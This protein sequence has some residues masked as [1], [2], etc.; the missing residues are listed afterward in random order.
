ML[1]AVLAALM[2]LGC[3]M[4]EMSFENADSPLFS[5][6]KDE[7]S[8]ANVPAADQ[9]PSGE[10]VPAVPAES[11][12]EAKDESVSSAAG[13]D[14]S[15]APAEKAPSDSSMAEEAKKDDSS[16][17]TTDSS[18]PEG[19]K[20]GKEKK[21]AVTDLRQLNV[22]MV[23]DGDRTYDADADTLLA[24]VDYTWLVLDDLSGELC[25]EL[26][27]ALKDE[28]SLLGKQMKTEFADLKTASEK[29]SGKN[30][31][32]YSAERKM[33]PVRT[34]NLV[35]SAL[36]V[37]K[38]QQ[39]KKSDM[40]LETL[41][42]DAQTGREIELGD[43]VDTKELPALLTEIYED[44]YPDEPVSGFEKLVAGYDDGDYVWALSREGLNFYFADDDAEHP[45]TVQ[46]PRSENKGLFSDEYADMPDSFAVMFNENS[47]YAFDRFEDGKT[48]LLSV[49]FDSDS[50]A[51]T[52]DLNGDTAVG[53]FDA[54]AVTP[55]LVRTAEER[56]YIYVVLTLDNDYQELAVFDITDAPVFLGIDGN[57]GI[58]VTI[59]I[60]DGLR[61]RI[62]S[63]S[64]EELMFSE[65]IDLLST[66]DGV[67]RY[68]VGSDGMPEAQDDWCYVNDD[69][70]LT[71]LTGFVADIVNPKTGRILEEGAKI[72]KGT[73]LKIHRTDGKSIVD[74]MTEDDEIIRVDVDTSGGWPQT[75]DGTDIEK[76][77]D[78]IRFAG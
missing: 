6:K 75:I 53:R 44:M 20:N 11:A 24:S 1:A 49:S 35:F 66:Y 70:E 68:S 10:S 54:Y 18:A 64:P 71:V 76:L 67:R 28:A 33:V 48:D 39:G 32:Q 72:A 16:A 5:G 21:P 29:A 62:F 13:Q 7:S 9:S 51:V 8:A 22:K 12:N 69:I 74:L 52:V 17:D 50:G 37:V 36:T 42:L 43:I 19:A 34:D 14:N 26:A 58:P 59:D 2:L 57:V 55:V 3:S 47:G 45:V 31:T 46:L 65:H 15:A 77:F 56:Y 63:G 27:D 30:K 40:S 73:E 4:P 60:E 23:S 61:S 41:N 38:E 25:P 78:G